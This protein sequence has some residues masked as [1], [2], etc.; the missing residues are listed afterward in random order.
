MSVDAHLTW[1]RVTVLLLLAACGCGDD[2]ATSVDAS[3]DTAPA[4]DAD[5]RTTIVPGAAFSI[6]PDDIARQD[7]DP[8]ITVDARGSLYALWYSNRGMAAG[9]PADKQVY[10]IKST[11]GVAWSAPVAISSGADWAFAPSVAV[12]ATGLVAT[13]WNWHNNATGGGTTNWIVART[14]ADG[15]TW[16]APIEAVTSG[17]GDWLPAVVDD[18][19]TSRV[20]VYFAAVARRA[21]GSIDT[22]ESRSRLFVVVKTAAGWGPVTPL[23]AVNDAVTH[24]SYPFVLRRADGT[25]A[26]T[27]TRFSG[28]DGSWSAVLTQP[29]SETWVATSPDGLTWS[30]ARKISGPAVNVFPSLHHDHAG[31]ALSV[32]WVTTDGA[33]SGQVVELPFQ[34]TY[35][36]DRVVRANLAGYTPRVHATATPGVY[37]GVWVQ[38]TDPNQRVRGQF[39][40]K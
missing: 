32:T 21:D 13:W 1:T 30:S 39:F 8:A 35:P 9:G 18:P 10:A 11:D 33:A 25:F 38:G 37:W 15:L 22:S 34:G 4:I 20:L 31:A 28:T 5:P 16:S 2:G 19:T 23:A 17:L 27:W 6:G 14:S 3:I 7:E 40:A 12:T 36:A 26:M 24:Q 29:A